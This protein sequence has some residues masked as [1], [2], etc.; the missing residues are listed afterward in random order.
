MTQ[1]LNL[2]KVLISVD[3]RLVA[4]ADN[5]SIAIAEADPEE[6]ERLKKSKRIILYRPTE[7]TPREDLETKNRQPVPQ[8]KFLEK[9]NAAGYRDYILCLKGWQV[10]ILHGAMALGADHPGV[11]GMSKP[12]HDAIRLFRDW[13]KA[14]FVD[15]G[16]SPGEALFLDTMREDEEGKV[17]PEGEQDG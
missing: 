16:F 2:G 17:T 9:L 13:C 1:E 4:T 10:A 8:G 5:L 11:R 6:M 15:W 12:T 7:A 3:N 14:V